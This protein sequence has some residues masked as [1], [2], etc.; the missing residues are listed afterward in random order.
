MTRPRFWTPERLS[1]IEDG[2]DRGLTDDTIARQIGCTKNAVQIARKRNGIASRSVVMLSARAVQERM[3]IGCAKT[4]ARW[5]NKGWLKGRRGQQLG[6][7]R[8]WY[9]RE[10]DLLSFLEDPAYWYAWRP[11]AI[12]EP[13]LRSWAL[14]ERAYRYLSVGEVAK[15]FYVTTSAV[16]AWIHQGEIPA[17]KYGNWWIRDC[18]LKGFTPPNE[19]P[20]SLS[21]LLRF[22]P[23]D[24]ATLLEL[25][26]RGKG[27]TEIAKTIGKP[28]SSVFGRA[29]RLAVSP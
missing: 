16:N 29:H 12:T 8:M 20:R 26:A 25:R 1:M 7:Y 28:I 27:W 15:R 6:P 22:T 10:D 14:E 23:E 18:D 4:V 13:H 17:K 11:E 19:R 2:I 3:G 5:I 9:V 21:K 24:D